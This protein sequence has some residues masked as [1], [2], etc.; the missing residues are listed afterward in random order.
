MSR[1]PRWAKC[2]GAL[3]GAALALI[4]VLLYRRHQ[5][6]RIVALSVARAEKLVRSDT[7]LG[8][9]EAAALL[10]VRAARTDPVEAGAL[11]AFALAM[12]ALDYR[13]RAAGTEAE[14]VLVEPTRAAQVPRAA[15]LALAALSLA[16]G[17]AGT[18]LEH[19]SRAGEGALPQLLYA[20]TALLAGNPR[21]ASEGVDRALA[22]DQELPGA[23]SLRG[24]LL[25][26]SG[27]PSEAHPAYLAALAASRREFEAGLA[28][29][30][31]RAGAAAPHP[32][33]T[34]G[35]AKLALSR[36]ISREEATPP[37]SRLVSDHAGTPQVERARAALFLAALQARAGDRAGAKATLDQTGLDGPLRAWLEKAAGQVEVER[38]PYRVPDAT[39]EVL[40]S[41]SDDDPY[42]PPPPP[43][44]KPRAAPAKPALHGFKV[45]PATSKKPAKV[46]KGKAK[47]SKSKKPA[48]TKRQ[49]ARDRA[50]AR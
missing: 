21:A 19:V 11:R 3:L 23:L 28:G 38:G 36:E 35:L 24:D 46:A 39:P 17:K 42:V 12:L 14:A 8:Y 31:A 9:H 1:L 20:R 29:S 33:A 6:R 48:P 4:A 47:G 37:L 50:T 27:R 49:Q 22:A 41:A 25:R 26:R 44:A 5:E 13:D 34:Y 15:E 16:E 10:G 43:P 2:A 30:S 40:L 18:A 32:R 7:W 45:H